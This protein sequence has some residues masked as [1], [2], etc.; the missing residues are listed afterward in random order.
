MQKKKIQWH[1]GFSAALRITLQEE[2]EFLEIQEEYLLSRKP[3]QIDILILKKKKE[4]TIRKAIGRIFRR[5]NIIEYKSPEDYLTI[6]D[7]YKVYAY[8]CVYQSNTDRINE[9]DPRE[10]TITFVCSHFPREMVRHLEEVRG[11]HINLAG[12]GIYYLKGDPIPIQL[13]ITPELSREESYWMQ[14]LRTDLKAGGEIRELMMRY[15]QNRKRK[16]YEAVMDLITRANWEQME[17]EKKMCDAL[18]ELFAEELKE[19]DERGRAAGMESGLK[20]GKESGRTE[21]IQLAKQVF[22]LSRSGVSES[23]IARQCGITVEQV[24]E[25]LE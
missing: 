8:A 3:L 2:M 7:F 10:R 23:E 13:L 21:G 17:E 16:D 6:N 1:Q 5:Y 9:V 25:I 14:N 19:A 20:A 4:L 11:I 15:E 24:K 18:N 12:K 22:R